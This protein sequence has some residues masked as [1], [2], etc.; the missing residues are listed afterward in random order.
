[1]PYNDGKR[2][3]TGGDCYVA[4]VRFPKNGLP[5]IET[6]NTYG[7][8]SKPGS[9]HF[10]DQVPLFLEQKTKPMTLDKKEVL[11]NAKRIYHPYSIFK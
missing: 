7:A 2:K 11:A 9:P 6:V 3:V 10:D 1:M 8:S 4:Y 5:I